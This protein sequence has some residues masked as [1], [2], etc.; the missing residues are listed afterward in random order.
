MY[1]GLYFLLLVGEVYSAFSKFQFKGMVAPCQ[2]K[3]QKLSWIG[4]MAE[5]MAEFPFFCNMTSLGIPGKC[6]GAAKPI[7]LFLPTL[8]PGFMDCLCYRGNIDF[9]KHFLTITTGIDL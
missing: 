8:V 7:H 6:L 9:C 1:F 4:G 3:N 5:F 2:K